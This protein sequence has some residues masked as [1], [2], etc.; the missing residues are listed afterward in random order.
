M[1]PLIYRS[2]RRRVGVAVLA[3]LTVGATLLVG[4]T[5]ASAAQ[6]S[7]SSPPAVPNVVTPNV[8]T[9][10]NWDHSAAVDARARQI[11]SQM[12]LAQKV[13][14]A[15]GQINNNFGFYNN[16]IPEVGIPAQT[17][18]DGPVGVRVANPAA[19]NGGKTTQL[20]S[21]SALAATF[22]PALATAYGTLIGQEA[23]RTGNNM[24]L[25]P[26]ADTA[27]TPLWGRAFEGFGEDPLL[28]GTLDGQYIQGVQSNPGVGATIKH[29]LVYNQETDRFN[30][31]AQVSDRALH[32]IYNRAFQIGIAS[33]HPAAA[34]CSFNQINGVP[35]CGNSLMT[36]L[37]KGVDGFRGFVMS[38]Y[39]ATPDTNNAANSGLDQNQ[40]GD[41]GPG[42]AN[43][44]DRLIAAVNAGQVPISRVDDM[45]LR[46]LRG[47]VGLG[48]LD[49]PAQVQDLDIAAGTALARS[50]AAQA[51]VLLK[52]A[53]AALPLS[54]G[55]SNK[56]IAV[57]GPDADNTSAQGGGSSAVTR[58][59][60]AVSP[61]AGITARA[62]AGTTV[63]Y[64][65]GADGVTEGS[66]LPGPAAIP[67]SVLT[68]TGGSPA[69]HGLAAQYWSNAT[70]SGAPH[71][72][73]VDPGV[74]TDFGF[75]NFPGFN[76]ASPKAHTP[77][78]DFALTGDLSAKWSGTITAPATGT[79]HLGLTARGDAT[80]TLDG[81]TFLTH[82]AAA[83]SS[84][85]RSVHLIAGQPHAITISYHAPAANAYQG[86]QVRLFW[87]HPDSVMS[88][89]MTA[90]VNSARHAATAIVV[91]RDYETEGV[92]RPN[93]DLPNE[94][95]Q[96]IRQ[97]A[98]VN[99]HTIVVV[100][101][102]APST[103]ST[104]DKNVAGV[105]QAWYPGQEQGTAIADVLF[106]DVDPSGHLPVTAPT[107]T[108][109]VPVPTVGTVNLTEGI[110]V[111]YRG[112]QHNN[113]QVE[114]PFGYGLSY[115]SFKYSNLN[116]TVTGGTAATARFTVT[117][118]GS[119]AGAEVPQVYVGTLPTKKV[120]TP[121]RQLAGWDKITLAPGQSKT[122]TVALN[123]Q[124]MSYWDS[125]AN[126]WI[127]PS[128]NLKVIVGN[129]ATNTALTGTVRITSADVEGG[130]KISQAK[131]YSIQN[132]ATSKC[133]DAAGRGTTNGTPVQMYDCPAPTTNQ[134]W[135][136]TST[137]GGFFQIGGVQA[138]DKVLDVTG[139]P[140]STA[141]GA[142]LQLWSYVGGTNQ[143]F[144]PVRIGD[145]NYRFVA[146]HSGKCI[147]VT[148]G[149]T[150]NGALLEQQT[151]QAG[152]TAQ[153]FKLLVQPKT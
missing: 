34:M 14:L 97:V 123:K 109:Q 151:C 126:K 138:A 38:D 135:T 19:T 61:L 150:A 146:L 71:L 85:S 66:L 130:G 94:Q 147:G 48:L 86:G 36:S 128:G 52:N 72:S 69:A 92:D 75:Q 99:P 79:Y 153:S 11:L 20:P 56:S 63:T 127:M 143:Q 124:S 96:L 6:P 95:D 21:G 23:F 46:I 60:A 149:S 22:D 125:Y 134:R 41:Q 9:P 42:T 118:T 7:S 40:P 28:T 24:S 18:A 116:T 117:N 45:A 47:M 102:G 62:G 64:Q 104:W 31:D 33:G 120:D 35:A 2:E 110:Y 59:T 107:N 152:D 132:S 89:A 37:L 80:F 29:F 93:L 43:F 30:V 103:M 82:T 129:S 111:G 53:Q 115:T 140:S 67:S 13:D 27:R 113:E 70:F 1:H 54:T 50:V 26:S 57:I 148:G 58:P 114:Y 137:S 145:G 131:V 78:G 112:Y 12:T 32:E 121:P 68:P 25:A 5:G 84:I 136:F 98:K 16:P 8:I 44:G 100:E 91:V 4:A 65:P 122:V 74:N 17:M 10:T 51:M 101:T 119:V 49:H 55:T 88:P 81:N 3:A 141:D 144:K 39:N 139:G 77:V 106:G 83:L 108:A 76:V 15:T 90:A 142:K 105:V 133:F 87:T 73:Q